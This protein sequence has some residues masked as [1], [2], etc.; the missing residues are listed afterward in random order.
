MSNH[1]RVASLLASGYECLKNADLGTASGLFEQAL[2]EDFDDAEVLFTLK[3]AEFWRSTLEESA[4]IDRSP[5][6]GDFMVARWKSFQLFLTRIPGDFERARYAFRRL[7]FSLALD[8]YLGMSEEEKSDPEREFDFRVGRCRKMLGDYETAQTHLERAVK[9]RRD[10]ARYLAEL[11]DCHAM[12]GE[13]RNAKVLFREAFFQDP[14]AVEFELIESDI[15]QKLAAIAREQGASGRDIAEW[16]PVHG[17]LTGLFGVKRELGAP[18]RAR[19][20]SSIFQ[21]ENDMRENPALS[22][23]LKPRLLNR[24]FWLLDHYEASGAEKAKIDGVLLK[25]RLLDE[26]IFKQYVA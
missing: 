23:S 8:S 25:L 17:E 12:S 22:G 15:V 21:L 9:L 19:L 4:S 24:Y 2:H 18:E 7:A 11:A 3:C 16:I 1:D 10:S 5:A 14:Q 6:R 20:T 26:K 13:Q